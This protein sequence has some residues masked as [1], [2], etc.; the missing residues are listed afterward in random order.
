MSDF[1]HSI[2][3]LGLLFF[4]LSFGFLSYSQENKE[5]LSLFEINRSKDADFIKYDLNLDASG[6]PSVSQP[7]T[8]YWIRRTK[9]EHKE[10]LTWIQNKYAYGIKYLNEKGG[11]NYCSDSICFQFVSYAEKTFTLKKGNNELYKVFTIIE[12]KEIEVRGIFVQIDGGSF[13]FPTISRVDLLGI[14]LK[15]GDLIVESIKN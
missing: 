13:W 7:I 5:E 4:L 9:N 15:N 6:K 2:K 3:S 8:V 12:S 10:P 14:D 1:N 11:E